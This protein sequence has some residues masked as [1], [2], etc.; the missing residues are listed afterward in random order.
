MYSHFHDEVLC[1]MKRLLC[2]AIL[3]ALIAI[4]SIGLTEGSDT[5]QLAR[6]IYTLGRD[7]SYETLLMIGSVVMNRTDSPW[8]P[9]TVGE[10][11]G[12]PHQFAHGTRY[13][14]RSLQAAREVM[15]GNRVLPARITVFSALDSS[16]QPSNEIYTVSGNYAFYYGN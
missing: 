2:T 15:M 14:S 7:E 12:E 11:L 8:Y 4:P 3:L 10:V 5:I 16:Y 6:T 13:D 9:D 1:F